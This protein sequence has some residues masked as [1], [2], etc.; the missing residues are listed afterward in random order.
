MDDT[1]LQQQIDGAKAY[2]S[3]HVPALFAQWPGLLLDAV[4][5]STG[6]RVLDVACGTGVLARAA[7]RRVSR[8]GSV[9]PGRSYAV[10]RDML[11]C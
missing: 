3:L 7:A 4:G 5:T 10:T 1:E 8:T 6:A 9:D 2:E 11:S